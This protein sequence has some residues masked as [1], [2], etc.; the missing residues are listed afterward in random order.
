MKDYSI[1]CLNAISTD[2][3]NDSMDL[4]VERLGFSS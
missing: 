4:Q 1:N 3:A 2:L